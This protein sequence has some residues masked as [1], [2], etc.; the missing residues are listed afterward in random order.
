MAG[1]NLIQIL[2]GSNPT[3]YDVLKPGQ[4]FYNKNKGYLHIGY[5]DGGTATQDGGSLIKVRELIGYT[6][7]SRQIGTS[8]GGQYYLKYNNNALELKSSGTTPIKIFNDSEITLDAA[9][10]ID[11]LTPKLSIATTNNIITT[12]TI[13]LTLKNFINTDSI[14]CNISYDGLSIDQSKKFAVAMPHLNL[15]SFDIDGSNSIYKDLPDGNRLYQ[16]STLD[17]KNVLVSD[18]PSSNKF[19]NIFE[20][21]SN[22]Y[23]S[24]SANISGT[25]VTLLTSKV[26]GN[27]T[28]SI[29]LVADNSFDWCLPNYSGI[30]DYVGYNAHPGVNLYSSYIIQLKAKTNLVIDTPEIIPCSVNDFPGQYTASTVN[31]GNSAY[32]FNKIYGKDLGTVTSAF[33]KIYVDKIYS[34]ASSSLAVNTEIGD[35]KSYYMVAQDLSTDQLIHGVASFRIRCWKASETE[36]TI[37]LVPPSSKFDHAYLGMN[38]NEFSNIYTKRFNNILVTDIFETDN[39]TVKEATE[40]KIV[41]GYGTTTGTLE[42]SSNGISTNHLNSG[43][44]IVIAASYS[45]GDGAIRSTGLMYCDF[46]WMSGGDVWVYSTPFRYKDYDGNPITVCL[47]SKVDSDFNTVSQLVRYDNSEP[48]TQSRAYSL[49]YKVIGSFYN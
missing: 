20:Q 19:S 37:A 27:F 3:S 11:I 33:N 18:G 40:A 2:R 42:F 38:G 21:T 15:Y 24:G 26:D 1:N 17:T 46:T 6:D 14:K 35:I 22:Y 23:K 49:S 7:D 4:L 43:S 45:P 16:E 13:D 48:V 30:S 31:L 32:P 8:K 5:K 34:L 36:N 29:A 12:Q 47:R 28:S 39:K 41:T 9:Q 44:L 10:K 25:G